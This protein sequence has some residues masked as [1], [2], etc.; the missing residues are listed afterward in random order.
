MATETK[1]VDPKSTDAKAAEAKKKAKAPLTANVALSL[2]AKVHTRLTRMAKAEGM[3]LGHYLQK[4]LETHLLE[5]AEEGDPVA[6]RLRAK[7][8]VIDHVVTLAQML[9]KDGKFD[10]NFVLT[11]M[12]SAA[13]DADFMK[14]YNTAIGGEGKKGVRQQKPLNQQLGRLIRK[15]ANAKTKRS[16]EGKAMR[17]QVS[18]EIIS[19]YS[20]LAR[21]EKA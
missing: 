18:G 19:S 3:E 8:A 20:L 11:V 6:E 12:K 21:V 15:A 9:D 2:D 5:Q 14:L 1:A 4:V 7:R 17:A 10:E 13:Q 16:E